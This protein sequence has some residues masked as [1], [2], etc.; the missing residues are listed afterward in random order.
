LLRFIS[1]KQSLR[2]KCNGVKL[3]PYKVYCTPIHPLGQTSWCDHGPHQAAK[4]GRQRSA[5]TLEYDQT[6]S[7]KTIL[8]QAVPLSS[9]SKVHLPP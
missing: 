8:A 3:N 2:V 9:E 5:P 1:K 4:K 7:K 6:V